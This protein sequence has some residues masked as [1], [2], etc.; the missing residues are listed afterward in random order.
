[1]EGPTL[2]RGVETRT[3]ARGVLA[4]V[5]IRD[6]LVARGD[7]HHPTVPG[8]RDTEAIRTAD[9]N[10]RNVH[11]KAERAVDRVAISGGDRRC[12]GRANSVVFGGDSY[13]PRSAR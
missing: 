4:S 13:E 3:F 10:A 7:R 2:G 6:R 1:M 11:A 5:H 8:Q 12:L 9:R